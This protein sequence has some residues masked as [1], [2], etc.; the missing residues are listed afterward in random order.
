MRK[1]VTF[2]IAASTLVALVLRAS[3]RGGR[4]T[5]SSA[6]GTPAYKPAA[7]RLGIIPERDIYQ[8]RKA[9]R[10]LPAHLQDRGV[11]VASPSAV[12]V[13]TVAI[14][15]R[16]DIFLAGRPDARAHHIR[17]ACGGAAKSREAI[18]KWPI[19][20]CTVPHRTLEEEVYGLKVHLDYWIAGP[21]RLSQ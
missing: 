4:S 14:A 2:A 7:L 9:Y 10:T 15:L 5:P 11:G 21:F 19:L 13:L 3:L 1:T 18:C 17:G 12:E 20:A 6:N 16:Q 8:Q